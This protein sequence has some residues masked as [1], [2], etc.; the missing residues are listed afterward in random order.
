V[1]WGR[2]E[3]AEKVAAEIA[4]NPFNQALVFAGLGDKERT[5]EALDRMAPLG[6]VRV[7][8]ALTFP[9][10]AFIRSNSRIKTLRKR[11]GLPE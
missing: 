7:G 3:D 8:R 1:T 2:R 4:P 10:F 5:L 9:E 11:T 6:P